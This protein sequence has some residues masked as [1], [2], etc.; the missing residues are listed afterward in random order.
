DAAKILNA[1]EQVR[2]EG[3]GAADRTQFSEFAATF[4]IANGVAQNQDLR[5]IAPRLSVTGAASVALA[6]RSIDYTARARMRGGGAP[7]PGTVIS[8]SNLEI[9]L[10]ITGPWSA[11]N[12]AIAGQEGLA[13]TVRQIGKNL[14]GQE[15]EDAVKGL[16]G[17][18]GH[19]KPS[20]I[21]DK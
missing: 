21:L 10:R 4:L 5:L 16:L 20:D 13:A 3:F 12:V 2:L 14:G 19:T 6:A 7:R 8:I 9:P 17:G 1:I 15:V 11:P 18:D